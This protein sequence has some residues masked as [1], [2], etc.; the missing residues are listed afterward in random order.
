MSVVPPAGLLNPPPTARGGAARYA[1]CDDLSDLPLPPS[2]SF[3]ACRRGLIPI[4]PKSHR[5]VLSLLDMAF[6]T[7]YFDQLQ[8]KI[9]TERDSQ[10]RKG[11]FDIYAGM[12][13]MS[14]VYQQMAQ[15]RALGSSR[16]DTLDHWRRNLNGIEAK[17][18]AEP[19][20]QRCKAFFK[21]YAAAVRLFGQAASVKLAN[22]QSQPTA[23][24]VEHEMMDAPPRQGK[25][26]AQEPAP[27]RES[28]VE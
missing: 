24:A 20:S 19:D 15:L 6:G 1:R 2:P 23:L 22:A 11:L 21:D 13:I 10:R 12:I 9:V 18:A 17:I 4:E 7:Q 5:Q 25:E 26:T 3:L 27:P 14:D 16:Y 28:G 8:A